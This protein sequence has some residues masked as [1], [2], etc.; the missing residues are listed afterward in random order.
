ML[1]AGKNDRYDHVR[2]READL[3]RDAQKVAVRVASMKLESWR[4]RTELDWL[5]LAEH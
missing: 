1:E 3:A 5:A 2:Q 4:C